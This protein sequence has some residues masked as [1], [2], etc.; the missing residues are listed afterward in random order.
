MYTEGGS[1]SAVAMWSVLAV[2]IFF[3]LA[4]VAFS[5]ACLLLTGRYPGEAKMAR[6]SIAAAI[7]Q[8]SASR[9]PASEELL[10]PALES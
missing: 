2:A 6:K 4:S 8:L 10:A 9:S 1:Q 7:E 3:W 5:F